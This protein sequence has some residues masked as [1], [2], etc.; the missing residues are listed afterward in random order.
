[1]RKILTSDGHYRVARRQAVD[2]AVI[3]FV[4]SIK[5]DRDQQRNGDETEQVYLETSLDLSTLHK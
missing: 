5:Y 2:V 3:G 4:R 1:M